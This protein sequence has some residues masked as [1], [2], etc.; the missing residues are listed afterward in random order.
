MDEL[1]DKSFEERLKTLIERSDTEKGRREEAERKK[2]ELH[3][4]NMAM[5]NEVAKRIQ[6]EIIV[7]R[8]EKLKEY[9]PFIE[10]PDVQPEWGKIFLFP[11]TKEYECRGILD[12][13]ILRAEEKATQLSC[14]C[15][16]SILPKSQEYQPHGELIQSVDNVNLSQIEEFVEEKILHFVDTYLKYRR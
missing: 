6:D 11:Y 2:M 15:S 3:E 9:F 13:H 1:A 14:T 10:E 16:I 7:P 8:M 4:A 5:F 12:I